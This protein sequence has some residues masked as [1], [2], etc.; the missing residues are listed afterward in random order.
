MREYT[1]NQYLLRYP[2]EIAFAFNPYILS[3]TNVGVVP[4][5][6]EVHGMDITIVYQDKRVKLSFEGFEKSCSIDLQEYIQ[7]LFS[8]VQIGVVDYEHASITDMERQITFHV[9]VRT[10]QENSNTHTFTSNFI[11]GALRLGGEIFNRF[12][13]L[14]WF[15]GYPFTFSLYTLGGGSLVLCKDGA[16]SRFI[17]TPERGI[18]NVPLNKDTDN[19]E[20]FYIVNDHT[21]AFIEGC[22]DNTFDMTFRYNQ[23]GADT[24]KLRIKIVDGCKNGYYLRWID[25]Q[26]FYQYFLFKSGDESYKITSTESYR[27]NLLMFEPG[28]GF[29]QKYGL[30]KTSSR[31]DIV[32]ICAPL[33]DSETWN[34]LLDV[35]TSPRVD[36]FAG[37]DN[38]NKPRW[39]NVTIESG[40]YLKTS[41]TLQ[42]FNCN[43]VMPSVDI[44][45]L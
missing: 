30:N 40:T 24:P 31:N 25:R 17:E 1:E 8:D 33:V 21:G 4:D 36:L 28:F 13:N 11:W 14:T 45:K 42:D 23:G 35:A 39:I 2:D 27:N 26:G 20:S 10:L 34:M 16:P 15:R 7:S 32:S 29:Q 5:I 22:F 43:I 19:A 3:A 44:Q 6:A 37:Y 18:W 12:R 41:N 38:E 9:K